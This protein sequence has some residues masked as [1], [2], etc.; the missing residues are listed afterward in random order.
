V[1]REVTERPEGV[2]AGVA[3]L[4]G[5]DPERICSAV[6]ELLR[7]PVAYGAMVG[8]VNPYGDGRAA[9]RIVDAI[10]EWNRARAA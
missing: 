6:D 10:L 4:V 2:A 8:P 1:L 5:T 9:A 3:R 7:N